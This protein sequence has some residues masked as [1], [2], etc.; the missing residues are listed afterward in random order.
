MI[1][2]FY[3]A[4]GGSENRLNQINRH[5]GRI[6]SRCS[7]SATILFRS[8]VVCAS[9]MASALLLFALLLVSAHLASAQNWTFGSVDNP[10]E[11]SNVAWWES[12]T[13]V[14]IAGGVSLIGP[15]WRSALHID[16]ASRQENTAFR[17][18]TTLRAGIYGRYEPDT[19]E[20]YDLLR[21]VEYARFRPV[22]G[23]KYLRLGPL[24]RTRL[25]QGQLV[26]FLSSQTSW[27]DRTVGAE[28]R[29]VGRIFT[30]EA[31]SSDVA[32]ASLAGARLSIT[33]FSTPAGRGRSLTL[34]AS[35]VRDFSIDL[36]NGDRFQGFET[37]LRVRVYRSGSFEFVP[38]VSFARLNSFGQG[39]LFGADLENDNFI[40]LARV[41]FRLALQYNS[42][43]F[44]PG[45][46]GSFY[47]VSSPSS[48]IIS[49]NETRR[50]DIPLRSIERGNAVNTE[51]R[52]LIFERFELWYAFM[53]YHGVQ[54][55]SE[56]HVR[57][58]FRSP[59]IVLA[60]GQD[61]RGLKGFASLFREL[62]DEN[63]MR[64]EFDLRLFSRLWAQFDAHYTYR[65]V[66]RDGEAEYYS[67]QRRFDPL[68]GL[69]TRF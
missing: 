34:G 12:H 67:V 66:L 37:D 13:D 3:T 21:L 5:T 55:L 59:R 33:P 60:I 38:F 63:R 8:G 43:D 69:R 48:S 20:R 58:F 24:D 49:E 11:Q 46:F 39:L 47:P 2:E 68:I 16:A 19:D 17:I 30:L 7:A 45:I 1:L 9:L 27:D 41:H 56:Y 52:I 15:Q 6:G 50:S 62:G 4:F 29:V 53:R 25:G 65:S 22:S 10:A 42:S 18:G 26:N 23:N 51:L 61:R 14:Q 54:K 36:K 44:R 64:F 28:G 40:D 32:R 57:L 35:L 31:F